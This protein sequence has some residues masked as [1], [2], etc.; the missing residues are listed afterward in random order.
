MF[1]DF[2]QDHINDNKCPCP[3]YTGTKQHTQNDAYL[4]AVHSNKATSSNKLT[5]ENKYR[6]Q[7][8]KALREF[9]PPPSTLSFTLK[10]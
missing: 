5:S 9:K 6:L 3:S 1:L 4:L 10:Y 8:S 7:N 2:I